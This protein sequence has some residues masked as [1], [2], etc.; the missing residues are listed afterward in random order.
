MLYTFLLLLEFLMKTLL[1]S[2]TREITASKGIV[3]SYV[4]C[5]KVKE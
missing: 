5:S 3:Q 4:E 1:T 2:A